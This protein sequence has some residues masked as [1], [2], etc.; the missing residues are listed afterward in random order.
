MAKEC[1]VCR[2]LLP[3]SEFGKSASHKDNTQTRCKP[4]SRS[5]TKASKDRKKNGTLLARSHR[6]MDTKA[7]LDIMNRALTSVDTMSW[8][9]QMETR[10]IDVLAR[11]IPLL[12]VRR[13]QD[14]T[15]SDVGVRPR[16][17]SIDLWLPLQ[18]KACDATHVQFRMRGKDKELP[19]CD[20]ICIALSQSNA[21]FL[22]CKEEIPAMQIAPCGLLSMFNFDHWQGRSIDARVLEVEL[23]A[24]WWDDK[25]SFSEGHL[26]SEVNANHKMELAHIAHANLAFPN[27]VVKWPS[28]P[29]GVTDLIRDGQKEQYK[30]V[31][32]K[33]NVFQAGDVKKK[34]CTVD[35]AYE[36]GDNDWYVCGYT[37]VT[38]H[39]A[40][41]W[42]IPEAFMVSKGI[43][44]TR[45]SNGLFETPGGM[46][47]PL[48]IVGP[49]GENKDVQ[50]QLVGKMP[51]SDVET[52]TAQFLHVVR[53]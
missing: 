13:W 17:T 47:I 42:R 16:G 35:V 38:N 20:T 8:T 9:M 49:N 24:R 18:L 43:L 14:C 46:S 29:Q 34:L 1:R 33:G 52:D 23:T 32:R 7:R 40:L 15:K 51:R 39:I 31:Q 12:E 45:G 37:D 41:L 50:M 36:V 53:L 22:F 19:N 48:N 5:A 30:S 44:S 27:S 21:L 10:S 11:M 2:K 4:C 6:K 25:R 3:I 28:T 26:R